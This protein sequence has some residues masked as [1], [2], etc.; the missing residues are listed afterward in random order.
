MA[1]SL[2]ALDQE[3]TINLTPREW[4]R[5]MDESEVEAQL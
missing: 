5:I 1:R 4:Q 3:P 2:A